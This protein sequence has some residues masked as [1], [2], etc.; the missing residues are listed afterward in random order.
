M[1][2]V[3]EFREKIERVRNLLQREA[4]AGILLKRQ[5]NF[6]WIACGGHD[7]VAAASDI[8]SASILLTP[9]RV[10]LIASNI[11]VQRVL[12][13]EIKELKDEMDVEEYAWNQKTDFEVAN[14]LMQ[15]KKWGSDVPCRS[16]R[17][18]SNPVTAI[19]T[20]L[21]P[22]EIARYKVLGKDVAAVLQAAVPA[23]KPGMTEQ[24]A[25]SELAQ[26]FYAK[27]I[28][29]SVILVAADDRIKKYRHPVPKGNKIKKIV[30]I[31]VNAKRD[32]LYAAATRFVCFGKPPAPIIKR[33]EACC[34]IEAAAMAV[35]R[36]DT[37]I[38]RVLQTII[39]KYEAEGFPDEWRLHHQGGPIGYDGR[40]MIL[41]V[42]GLKSPIQEGQAFALN[43][44]ITG[45]KSEDTFI[46]QPKG[47]YIVT[48]SSGWPMVNCET[49]VGVIQ[50]PA[51]L[52]V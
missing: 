21:H 9:S 19:R 45:A 48:A 27:G 6:T 8:A 51:M 3:D 4:L 41:T 16:A 12:E 29:P 15:G 37:P 43:P 46:V 24:E 31:V 13:E 34:R 7:N 39:A 28:M 2:L 40:D 20:P 52:V 11:E 10:V 36:P 33:Q 17:T 26:R 32:G 44:S 14:A 23:V 5:A 50:R 22:N 42:P 25:A 30:M 49:P 38:G 18:A 47:P 1:N 35:A